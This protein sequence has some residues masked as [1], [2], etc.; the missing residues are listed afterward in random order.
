[1]HTALIAKWRGEIEPGKSSNALVQYADILPTL[2]DLAGK[3]SDKLDG[4][5]F[6]GV[7]KGEADTHRKFVYGMHNNFPE[8][9]PYPC[10]LYT[11][12]SPRDQ[13]GS[14]MPSSA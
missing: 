12:P 10:L 5:S 1:M 8:G 2:L 14:R 4:S 13:R 7:L 6:A 11:S 9:P 3:E